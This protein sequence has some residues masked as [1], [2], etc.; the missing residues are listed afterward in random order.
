MASGVSGNRALVSAGGRPTAQSLAGVS[1]KLGDHLD[2]TYDLNIQL[3]Q[4]LGGN[5]PLRVMAPADLLNGI[6]IREFP[7]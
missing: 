6:S 7:A 1:R 2:K 3:L 4:L 5:P